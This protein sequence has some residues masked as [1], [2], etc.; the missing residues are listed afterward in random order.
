MLCSFKT[1]WTQTIFSVPLEVV[2]ASTIESNHI[3]SYQTVAKRNNASNIV[4]PFSWIL[5]KNVIVL[6]STW[7]VLILWCSLYKS[8]VFFA[9]AVFLPHVPISPAVPQVGKHLY[10]SRQS[11][12]ATA[13]LYLPGASD[14]V[15]TRDSPLYRDFSIVAKKSSL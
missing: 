12:S 3:K 6:K 14:S 9:C 15:T 2:G 7:F 13:N 5:A 10:P 8:L 1:L 4:L 11:V